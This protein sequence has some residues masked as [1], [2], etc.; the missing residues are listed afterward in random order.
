MMMGKRRRTS[1][2]S[3]GDNKSIV[4]GFVKKVSNQKIGYKNYTILFT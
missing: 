1:E 2:E 4:Y 3:D